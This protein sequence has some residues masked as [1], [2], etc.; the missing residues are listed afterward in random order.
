MNWR[1]EVVAFSVCLAACVAAFFHESLFLGKVLSPADVLLVSASFRGDS[2]AAYEPANRLLMDPVLQFEPWLEFNRRMIRSGRL[3]LWNG[4]AGCGAPH[5]ANGQSAVFDPFHL[6]AYLWTVPC[7]LGWIAAC[8]LWVAGLG[9]FLLAR[10]W[11]LGRWGRWFAGLAYPYCGFLIVWLLYPVTAVAIWMPWLFLATDAIFRTPSPKGAGRLAIVVAL[12]V[13][14]GHIQTSAHVLL[15]GGLYAVARV[16]ARVEIAGRSSGAFLCWALGVCLGLAVASVQILPLAAY[17]AR[18]PVW[19]DRRL[20][21]Q[22]WWKLERPRLLELA[23][24]AVPYVY[25]SQRRGQPNLA[26]P[27]GV[28]NLNESAGGFAGLGTLL[29]LAP[30]AVVARG[31]S[32]RVAYLVGLALCGAMG[33]AR[34]PP[35]DNLLRALPVLE[36]TDNRRLSLWVAFALVLLG[37]IGLDSLGESRRL[38]RFWIGAWIALRGS[39]RRDGRNRT[40]ARKPT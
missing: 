12:V 7:A 22:A 31:R 18:S 1:R 28:N 32:F 16:V 13:L 33:A 8:R 37:G 24:T 10:S 34:I 38:A 2:A 19:S 5:L 40:L 36:V 39:V 25:G 17:L 26:R 15:A 14:G 6:I 30:L 3:P 11:G 4:S 23:C 27:L 20:E 35:V 21:H 9:M 29:W